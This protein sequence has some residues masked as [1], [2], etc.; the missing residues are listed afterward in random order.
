MESV[1]FLTVV[2]EG[3]VSV[4]T[5]LAEDDAQAANKGLDYIKEFL[6]PIYP[7][8]YAMQNSGGRNVSAFCYVSGVFKASLIKA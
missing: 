4:A 3:H 8:V 6:T 2:F 1:W 5:I 7:H